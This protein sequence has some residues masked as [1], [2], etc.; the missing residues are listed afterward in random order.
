MTPEK[1]AQNRKWYAENRERVL[2]R[3]RAERETDPEKFNARARDWKRNNPDRY[4]ANWRRN[5]YGLTQD[6]FDRMF[7]AQDGTCAIC[8]GAFNRT[9]CIDHCHAT[10]LV[11]GLLC[12]G[13]NRGLGY[14]K[15]DGAA[16][17]RAITYLTGVV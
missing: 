6:D 10:G 12:D 16:L 5:A 13:C 8:R 15:E 17:A 4:R 7:T 3:K 14:F 1:R 9:P 2:A 11:R